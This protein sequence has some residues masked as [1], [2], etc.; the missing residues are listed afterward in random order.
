VGD[1]LNENIGENM[2][3]GQESEDS[4]QERLAELKR[5]AAQM[6]GSK[7]AMKD[8][9]DNTKKSEGK[10]VHFLVKFLQSKHSKTVLVAVTKALAANV[11]ANLVLHSL[12]LT[13]DDLLEACQSEDFSGEELK[14]LKASVSNLKQLGGDRMNNPNFALEVLKTHKILPEHLKLKLHFWGENLLEAALV[15]P[16]KTFFNFQKE[17]AQISFKYLISV[18]LFQFFEINHVMIQSQKELNPLVDNIFIN[19]LEGI[20]K[21]IDDIKYLN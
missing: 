17:E 6:S 4:I 11:S 20:A 19:I 5:K 2:L 1:Q 21:R 3:G 12:F 7:K 8:E 18:I 9:E 14:K 13:N 15:Y 16:H 10:V